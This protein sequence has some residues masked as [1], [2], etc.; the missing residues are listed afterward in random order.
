MLELTFLEGGPQGQTVRL[1][2]EKAWFGRQVTCDF[3]LTGERVS[4]VHFSIERR[5]DDYILIDNLSKNGT[6]VNQIR[7]VAVTLRAGYE[8]VAGSNRILVR[9]AT[10]GALVP[11]RFVAER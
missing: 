3:V 1:T 2:F 10:A 8:I 9:E 4:R 11:F 5:G 7:T 6:F